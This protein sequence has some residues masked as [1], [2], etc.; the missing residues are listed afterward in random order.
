[1]VGEPGEDKE[2]SRRGPWEDEEFSGG[3]PGEANGG[4]SCPT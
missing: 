4:E 1:M 2:L 3:G